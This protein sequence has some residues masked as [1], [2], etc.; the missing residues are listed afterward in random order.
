MSV[1]IVI[2][3]N[4]DFICEAVRLALS[5]FGQVLQILCQSCVLKA[6]RSRTNRQCGDVGAIASSLK[7]HG[8]QWLVEHESQGPVSQNGRI[9]TRNTQHD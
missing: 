3:A 1:P 7:P 4:A 6:F 9:L 2:S 5:C 8:A